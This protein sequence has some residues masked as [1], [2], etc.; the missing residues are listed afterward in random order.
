[1]EG[2]DDLVHGHGLLGGVVHHVLAWLGVGEVGEPAV[3]GNPPDDYG[4]D[5]PHV[6]C[7]HH[8]VFLEDNPL[9]GTIIEQCVLC[10]A[11][12]VVKVA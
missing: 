11:V 2:L 8:F 12:R 6:A 5:N 3:P 7:E 1:M 9:T 10:G 4:T